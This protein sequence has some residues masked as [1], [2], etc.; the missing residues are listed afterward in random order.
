M[1]EDKEIKL[2][3]IDVEF[4]SPLTNL[5]DEQKDALL[6]RLGIENKDGL[7]H[8]SAWVLAMAR[9]NGLEEKLPCREIGDAIDGD[10]SKFVWLLA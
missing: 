9:E 6:E 2:R 5:T 3:Y 7:P 1:N 8:L 10:V 4:L